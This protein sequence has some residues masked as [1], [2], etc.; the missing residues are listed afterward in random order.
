MRSIV[1]ALLFGLVASGAVA[2]DWGNIAT[3]SS[4]L[5]N[6]TNRLCI[7]DHSRPGDIG[8]PAYA[9]SLTTAGDLTVSGTVTAAKFIGDGSGL[10]NLSASGDR[11]VSGTLSMVAISNTGYVSLTTAGTNWGY[12]SSGLSY[13]P[14]ISA[15]SMGVSNVLNYGGRTVSNIAGGGGN[16]IV[17][18]TTSV[19]T[20]NANGGTIKMATGSG[21]VMTISG[22]N[23]GIG[24]SNP[25]GKM[26]IY[27]ASNTAAYWVRG[28]AV[29]SYFFSSPGGGLAAVGTA[30]NH[31]FAIYVS[32]TEQMRVLGNGNVGIRT[33]NPTSTLVVN[34]TV[35]LPA[36]PNYSTGYYVC[37]YQNALNYGASCSA[38]D[39][40]LK[41]NIEP[42]ADSLDKITK[43]RGV[44][45]DWKDPGQ[46]GRGRNIGLIAQEVEKVF[47]EVV[48]NNS[49]GF[50]SLQYDKLVAPLVESV[51]EL[52]GRT[53][54]LKIDN[55]KQ[56]HEIES[57][58]R[59]IKAMK[60]ARR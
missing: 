48:G 4:T 56:Q 15:T 40:R 17:S 57:L 43:L 53:K 42:L 36:L 37:I 19:S 52:D 16:Y 20:S 12:L 58:Q 35:S 47:P 51:K 26:D 55:D 32:G 30:S 38:S 18:A 13:L 10:L 9:P 1:L 14:L 50:K 54:Q 31:P 11:I 3:I 39:I 24:T 7:G 23:V 29:Q 45:F 59:E 8:C 33:A 21:L 44:S 5:G 49:D 46:R 27:D 2:Q 6:N 34:G 22:S 25:L 41:K 28:G 60:A